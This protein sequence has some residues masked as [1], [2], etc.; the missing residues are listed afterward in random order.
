MKTIKNVAVED[1]PREKLFEKGIKS[2]TNTEL[3]AIILGSGTRD[4]NALELSWQ[5]M[6]HYNNNLSEIV[7]AEIYDLVKFKGIGNV[8]AATILAAL[9]LGIRTIANNGKNVKTITKS[10]DIYDI[11]RPLIGFAKYEE[12]WSLYLNRNLN[13][14]AKDKISEGSIHATTVDPRKIIKMGIDVLASSIVLCHNHPS[15]NPNPSKEDIALTDK[16]VNAAKLFDIQIIDHLIITSNTYFSFA[17]D[18][19]MPQ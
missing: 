17:D 15:G 18:G 2:M 4:N 10:N 19:I 16:M 1:R 14:I 11:F 5:I 9:E 7:K 3:L 13:V 12:F 8:K 6:D